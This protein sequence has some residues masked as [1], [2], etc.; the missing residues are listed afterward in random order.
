MTSSQKW[1]P[2]GC[3]RNSHVANNVTYQENCELLATT[4]EETSFAKISCWHI[5]LKESWMCN[6]I[7]FYKNGCCDNIISFTH[8]SMGESFET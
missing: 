2:I 6:W 4:L 5:T 3:E 7:L 1:K 8:P